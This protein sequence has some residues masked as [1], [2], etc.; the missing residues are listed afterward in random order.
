MLAL[1]VIQMDVCLPDTVASKNDNFSLKL[2]RLLIKI[3]FGVV[4]MFQLYEFFYVLIWKRND[5]VLFM[6]YYNAVSIYSAFINQ[7]VFVELLFTIWFEVFN[8]FH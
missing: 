6:Y 8:L 4:T 7:I 3:S 1:H 5:E 2:Y